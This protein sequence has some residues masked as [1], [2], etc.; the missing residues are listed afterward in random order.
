MSRK[1]GAALAVVIAAAAAIIAMA[2]YQNNVARI[3]DTN[4]TAP[5][6]PPGGGTNG[7][8]GAGPQVSKTPVSVLSSPSA[9]PFMEKWVAQYNSEKNLGSVNVNYSDRADDAS[10][11]ILYPNFT[12]FLADHSAD[13]A[14]AGRPVAEKGNFTYAGSVFLPVSPQAVAVVYNVPGLPDVP[15]GLKFDPATLYSVLSG[16]ATYW[17]D[18]GIKSL[19][20]GTSLPHQ[21]IVVVH[22]G[23]AGSASDMLE[24]YLASVSNSN[25]TIAWPKSSLVADSANRLSAMV[26]Q[27]PYSIGYIDFAF[28]VQTRMTYASLQNSDGQ[29]FMPSA[30]SIGSAVRNGTKVDPALINGT[31]SGNPSLATPPT[32]SVG[33][34]GNGSYPVVGFYYAAFSDR[35]INNS[36][37]E[38]ALAGSS[39]SSSSKDAAVI[40]LV[41]W[42]AGSEG[43]RILQDMQYP[44]VYVQN[45]DLGAFADRV[46]GTKAGLLAKEQALNGSSI[47]GA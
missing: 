20:P 41:R 33:Q 24:R 22:E 17:D 27:T 25:G 19:N 5:L 13:I 15:S 45:K 42:I 31:G 2:L 46:L 44:S 38:T 30:D 34:L 32:I 9:M 23:P 1:K 40:D 8:G 26:R 11:P 39:S 36:T 7:T 37:N 16:N 28:A 43:Q 10:I 4:R 35:A 47:S 3:P 29:Y 12:A 14:I 21:Q 18:P 6:P